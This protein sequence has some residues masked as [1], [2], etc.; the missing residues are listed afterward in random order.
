MNIEVD[1]FLAT[2]RDLLQERNTELSVMRKMSNQEI[3]AFGLEEYNSVINAKL[4]YIAILSD[5]VIVTAMKVNR[6][7][8][9]G[10]ALA[11]WLESGNCTGDEFYRA[12]TQLCC[13]EILD[14]YIYLDGMLD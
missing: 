8:P 9:L 13:Q 1:T 12:L 11:Q 4:D 10:D 7:V 14:R 6:G 3:L 2:A 5:F